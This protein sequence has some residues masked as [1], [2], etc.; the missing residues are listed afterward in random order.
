MVESQ[1]EKE[2]GAVLATRIWVRREE[3]VF[4]NGIGGREG[5]LNIVNPETS[6][7]TG[8]SGCSQCSRNSAGVGLLEG[9][10]ACKMRM[11]KGRSAHGLFSW[12]RSMRASANQ[13]CLPLASAR[14]RLSAAGR[15]AH[16][17]TPDRQQTTVEPRMLF[18]VSDR[19]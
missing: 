4:V 15:E 13:Q 12:C 19:R 6:K 7:S 11:K 10:I 17:L 9:N 5:N 16:A 8:T 2:R 18:G 3:G 14:Q 1:G